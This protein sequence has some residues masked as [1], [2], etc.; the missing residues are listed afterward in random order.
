MKKLLICSAML[1]LVAPALSWSAEQQARPEPVLIVSGES[2]YWQSANPLAADGDTEPTLTVDPDRKLQSWQGFGGT[3]AEAGWDVLQVV[4][5]EDRELALHLLFDRADGAG[6]TIG[7]IPIGASDYALD[8]YSLAPVADDYEMG[9]FSI[10]RDQRMLIPFIRAALEVNPNL[11]L[12]ASPWSPPPWM[13]T[14]NAFDRGDIRQ[15][16]RT[17]QAHALYLA[18]FV[19]E[20]AAAGI[21]VRA[22]HPQNEPGWPQDYPSCGWPDD[23]MRDYIAN[24]LGPLFAQ[25]LPRTEVWLGTMSNT[26]SDTIVRGVMGDATAASYIRGIGLQWGMQ[27]NARQYVDDYGLP[28]LQTEHRCGHYPWVV[29]ADPENYPDGA[30]FGPAPNDHEYAV[31]SWGL[32]KNWIDQGVNGYLAWNMVLDRNGYNLDTVRPWAQNSLLVVDR[33]AHRLIVTP[34]YY[35]FRHVAQF[36]EP[37]ATVLDVGDANALAWENAD[38]SIVTVIHNPDEQDSEF[39]LALESKAWQFT[40]P[41]LGWV[42]AIRRE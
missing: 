29:K 3:F 20:Y 12:W 40:I 24:H 8:R 35:V 1:L 41:A 32:I 22:V 13:K 14:N 25:R 33:E 26:K 4:S 28:T 9:H 30:A 42:T 21:E 34:A 11:V 31:E 10:D 36:V 7:R 16:P 6:F 37:G 18:R 38:G 2:S 19:E 39:V 17:L 15:D 23:S 27:Q 5:T